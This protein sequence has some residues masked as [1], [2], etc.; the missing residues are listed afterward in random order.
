[1]GVGRVE[2]PGLTEDREWEDPF[3]IGV[4]GVL[5]LGDLRD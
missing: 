5:S 4:R 3:V 1:M 2:G